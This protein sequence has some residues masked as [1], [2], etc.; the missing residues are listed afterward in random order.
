MLSC[1]N[2]G[3]SKRLRVPALRARLLDLHVLGLRFID[4]IY[5]STIVAFYASD[6]D[7]LIMGLIPT[8]WAQISARRPLHVRPTSVAELHTPDHPHA[9]TTTR[10]PLRGN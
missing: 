5:G 2:G 6:F 10:T 4:H 9:R 3:S 8:F 1:D 7:H